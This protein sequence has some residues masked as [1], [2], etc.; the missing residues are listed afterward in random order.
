MA[1]SY[2][3]ILREF[4]AS[5]FLAN[6]TLVIWPLFFMRRLLSDVGTVARA[7]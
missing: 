3:A 1:V 5:W 4:D 7:T 2:W 6:L